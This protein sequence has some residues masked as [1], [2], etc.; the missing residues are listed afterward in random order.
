MTMWAKTII[1][2]KPR[3][4]YKN[5]YDQVTFVKI[6]TVKVPYKI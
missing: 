5:S 2:I 4:T 6:T 1:A 3:K